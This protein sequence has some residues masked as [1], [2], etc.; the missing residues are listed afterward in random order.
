ML[1]QWGG[2]DEPRT[3]HCSYCGAELPDI[4][5]DD[6][7]M[8]LIL[9]N[10]EGWCAEFCTACQEKWWG[11]HGIDDTSYDRDPFMPLEQAYDLA[12]G[13][14]PAREAARPGRQPDIADG[15]DLGPC[16][17]CEGSENVH[18]IIMLHRRGVVPGHGWGCV[19][20]GLPS[21]GASA[22]LCE[23]CLPQWQADESLLKIACRGYPKSDGRIPIAELPAEIFDHDHSRHGLDDPEL[24]T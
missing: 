9:W 20:C 3:E 19:T 10:A 14:Q 8:P 4:D 13:R 15:P 5:D 24:S 11:I 1:V 16:C 22:V 18:N 17:I 21:D 23:T 7:E 12:M 2:P 6:Y